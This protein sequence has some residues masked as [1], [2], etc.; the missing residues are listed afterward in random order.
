MRRKNKK[1]R[2]PAS[3]TFYWTLVSVLALLVAIQ[4]LVLSGQFQSPPSAPRP[5]P[6]TASLDFPLSNEGFELVQVN[7]SPSIIYLTSGCS[8]LAMVTTEFQ[9]YSIANGLQGR[10]DF[11]PTTHD[12]FSDL[13]EGLGIRVLMA[14]IERMEGSVYYAKLYVQQD[15]RILGL[16]SKPSD[17]IAVAVRSGAP[18]YIASG[19]LEEQAV[20][21]C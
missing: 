9:S 17:A 20:S 8:Q 7:A 4:I 14:R 21:V 10:V 1:L 13:L 18:V 16:D 2:K 6:K 11:R 12:V 3:R 19:M 15:S 5:L